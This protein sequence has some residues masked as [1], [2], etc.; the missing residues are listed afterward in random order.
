MKIIQ[1]L[2]VYFTLLPAGFAQHT[3]NDTLARILDAEFAKVF[4][5]DGPGGSVFIQQAGTVL[6]QQSFGLAD[7]KTK[8]KFS[9]ATVANLGSIS[10]TFVA[11]GILLLQQRGKLSVDDKLLKYFPDFSN[12]EI[13]KKITIRHLM[14]HTSG[15]PDSRKTDTDSIFYLTAKD[16]E[17]FEPLKATDQLEFD[18]GSHWKYSNPAYNGL[19]LIIE[20]ITHQKWQDFIREN[21]FVP[22]QMTQSKITDGAYPEIGVAHGYRKINGRFEEY[23]YGEY[24]TFCAAGNGGVW[25][26]I[27]DLRKY[28]EAIKTCAFIDCDI[29]AKTKKVWKPANWSAPEPMLHTTVWFTHHGLLPYYASAGDDEVVEHTGDQGGFKAHLIWIPKKDMIIIWITNNDIFITNL[30]QDALISARLLN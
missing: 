8:E 26:S 1:L 29:I 23:D 15:L 24:P 21:I 18:P 25:S 22:A 7:L 3:R 13:A 19:A 12:K 28:A 17:N 6:Y 2:L 20:K 30:L 27:D 5:A 9:S 4:A 10:K 11:Y 16:A 14:S